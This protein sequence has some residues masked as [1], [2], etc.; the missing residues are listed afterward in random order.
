MLVSCEKILSEND[1]R[2]ATAKTCPILIR[3]MDLSYLPYVS[4]SIG[5]R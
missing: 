3:W 2:A 1:N 4:E 5:V